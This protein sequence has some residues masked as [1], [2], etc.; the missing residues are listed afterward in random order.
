MRWLDKCRSRRMRA[1]RKREK[2]VASPPM[3]AASMFLYF[4]CSRA[5]AGPEIAGTAGRIWCAALAG[6]PC[7]GAPC[8]MCKVCLQE[9][10]PKQ[11]QCILAEQAKCPDSLG[12]TR[13]ELP[14]G[15]TAAGRATALP[16]AL[17]SETAG[18]AV[19]LSSASLSRW[20]ASARMA[21]AA[22]PASRARSAA[23]AA[24][25]PACSRCHTASQCGTSVH[26]VSSAHV[27]AIITY[28][29]TFNRPF[30]MFQELT[31]LARSLCSRRCNSPCLWRGRCYQGGHA[32]LP[33]SVFCF[34]C[35]SL[36]G[37]HC[38]IG[39]HSGSMGKLELFRTPLGCMRL[40]RAAYIR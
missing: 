1:A 2:E 9:C 14:P 38:G 27:Q 13:M 20:S 25:R 16:G 40:H 18:A 32:S 31:G 35:S 3:Y 22:L 37:Q 30:G 28:C 36:G 17:A 21:L 34:I 7:A 23:C 5:A 11:L 8:S 6:P 26:T 29:E 39:T 19:L 10:M 24:P 15:L 12:R 4:S 33:A